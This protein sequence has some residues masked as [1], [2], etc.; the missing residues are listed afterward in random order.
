MTKRI[1]CAIVEVAPIASFLFLFAFS[2]QPANS[3]YSAE[4]LGRV[5][6][7][8]GSREQLGCL[9]LRFAAGGVGWSETSWTSGQRT[10][11]TAS[12]PCAPAST[13]APGKPVERRSQD[14]KEKHA[15]AGLSREMTRS[16]YDTT[17]LRHPPRPR[18]P[19]GS[20]C[21][22]VRGWLDTES[23]CTSFPPLY[24]GRR[25]YL[26][27]KNGT[28]IKNSSRKTL[29]WLVITVPRNS[30]AR[31]NTVFQLRED[32]RVHRFWS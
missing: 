27:N 15:Q 5:L 23:G 21:A 3:N 11:T 20:S 24:R 9:L 19:A 8:G 22:R 10:R 28:S 4:R 25:P 14:K 2:S 12:R 18:C 6:H 13:R 31:A 7:P 30:T 26:W 29:S 16:G 1:C 32:T 17:P